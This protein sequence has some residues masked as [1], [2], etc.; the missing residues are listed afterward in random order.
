[1]KKTVTLNQKA[2]SKKQLLPRTHKTPQPNSN[3]LDW[4]T[5]MMTRRM[6]QIAIMEKPRIGIFP[7]WRKKLKRRMGM[8][9]TLGALHGKRPS[10]RRH[11]RRIRRNEKKSSRQTRNSKNFKILLR[12]W[13]MGKRS[14][15]S[16]KQRKKRKLGNKKKTKGRRKR[17]ARKHEKM[18]GS[19]SNL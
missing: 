6:M 2:R 17:N 8:S 11:V 13:H 15:H 18:Q 7:S 19:K 9:M 12:L 1:M 5:T 16:D 3:W 14:R 10:R 4:E